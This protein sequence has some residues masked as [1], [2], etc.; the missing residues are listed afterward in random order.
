MY[1]MPDQKPDISTYRGID[2]SKAYEEWQKEQDELERTRKKQEPPKQEPR[3]IQAQTGINPEDYIFLEGKTG[4]HGYPDTLIKMK[5][6][7]FNRNWN[8]QHEQ[9][10]QN[11]MHMLTIR[12]FADFLTLLKTGKAYDGNGNRISQQKIDS[13]LDEI[14]ALRNPW[15]AEFLD[16]LF[17]EK[18]GVLHINYNHRIKNGKLQALNSEPLDC[19]MQDKTPGINLDSW[20]KTADKHGL[21][22][23]RTK[24]GDLR[25]WHPRANRAAGFVADSDW[26]ILDCY[27]YPEDSDSSLGVR[28]CV[29]AEDASHQG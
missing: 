23:T 22:T 7:L 5:K 6:S 11:G 15:R 21:P 9:L 4:K 10:S 18:N 27:R 25:Y 17:E 2:T 26:A 1:K 16:A 14:T 13:I 29:D 3:I 19:L 28:A 20:L 24:N 12:K 8:E